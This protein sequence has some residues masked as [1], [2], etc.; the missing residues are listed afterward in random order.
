MSSVF[1][2]PRSC[3][4]SVANDTYMYVEMCSISCTYTIKIEYGEC[5]EKRNATQLI[6]LYQ[7]SINHTVYSVKKKLSY[8]IIGAEAVDHRARMYT[9][10]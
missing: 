8:V 6:T 7:K 2:P 4:K 3:I 5:V 9:M 10:L 1:L